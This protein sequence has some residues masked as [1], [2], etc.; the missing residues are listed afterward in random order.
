MPLKSRGSVR[1]Y[2]SRQ[3][4]A[5][6]QRLR[7]RH[8]VC[9]RCRSTFTAVTRNV[10]YCSVECRRHA[11]NE[12]RAATWRAKSQSPREC[13]W[14][15]A[16]FTGYMASQAKFCSES[17]R[18]AMS[19]H[20][21]IQHHR[22]R[23]DIPWKPCEGC[24]EIGSFYHHRKFCD[25]C[26]AERRR[27][28]WRRK[29]AVRRGAKMKGEKFT[30]EEVGDR[31][32]WRCHLCSKRVNPTIANPDPRAPTIDHLIPVAAGGVDELS[33]VALAHRSCNCSRGAKGL[34]QLRLAV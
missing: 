21:G 7:G 8:N 3:C 17:C 5:T 31:D 1:I 30:L 19:T 25:D 24:G 2:C 9:F 27:G 13:E 10:K 32:G 12:A 33:N 6:A 34:A 20:V 28:H 22:D 29:N 16:R 4:N 18:H 26:R 11:F 14:C 23:C 15:F